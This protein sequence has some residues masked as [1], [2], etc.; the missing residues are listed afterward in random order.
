M[1][2]AS[3]YSSSVSRDYALL[4][5]HPASYQ[6]FGA[7]QADAHAQDD[8][9]SQLQDDGEERDDIASVSQ[10]DF[11]SNGVADDGMSQISLPH[12]NHLSVP[13]SPTF[14]RTNL[15]G[16][17]AG[18]L[19]PG[20]GGGA[21]SGVRRPSVNAFPN[22]AGIPS[23][24]LLGG[25][26][27]PP[28]ASADTA[29]LSASYRDVPDHISDIPDESDVPTPMP[30]APTMRYAYTQPARDYLEYGTSARR[31]DGHETSSLLS[32]RNE[33]GFSNYGAAPH[34]AAPNQ[35]M[36]SLVSAAGGPRKRRPSAGAGS[37]TPGGGPGVSGWAASSMV[38]VPVPGAEQIDS[39][40]HE[41]HDHIAWREAKVVTQYTI[42]IW[43]TH[44]LE[45]S[46]SVASV[47][48]LGHLGTLELAAA[49]LSSMTANVSGYSVLS[50]FISALD[51][52]LPSAYTQQPKSV[53]LWT[54]RMLV[55]IAGLLP[56]IWLIWFNAERILVATGQDPAVAKL[57]GQ[58]LSILA[59]GLPGYASFEVCRRYLQAQGLMH[60][61]TL[62]LLVVSPLN[63]IANYALVWGPESIR[64]GFVG[65][66]M[67][68]AISMWVMAL[69]C[70][71]QCVLGPRTAWDGWS[72]A[73]FKW[74]GIRPVLSLGF[75]GM[76]SLATEWWAWEIVGLVTAALGTTALAAQSVL[77][78]SSS[79]TYQL[80]FG[81][82]VATAVRIGNLLGANRPR[83]ARISSNVSLIISLA[84]GGF[85]SA[86]FLIF[87]RQWGYLFSSDAEVIKL[88]EHILPI[89][90]I[91]QVADG[92]CGIAGGVLRGTGRQAQGAII[93]LT[94]YYFVGIPI[95]L[96]LTF[97]KLQM[98]LEGLWWGLTIA[99]LYGSVGIFWLICRTDWEHEVRK[100]QLRM[101]LDD[102]SAVAEAAQHKDDVEAHPNGNALFNTTSL[103][104]ATIEEGEEDERSE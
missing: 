103:A 17:A 12:Q 93:N 77:L 95:G 83:E 44:L 52:I 21:A 47:F 36:L 66:P 99:L 65:A 78:V 104:S 28:P 25:S 30:L 73:A 76:C 48:S 50:G 84:M 56:L 69:L 71:L 88:V 62:V 75:A 20:V 9:S 19:V 8:A 98:G 102:P 39:I 10:D 22:V 91:F 74:A 86:L 15:G 92:V 59:F 18:H 58:Y 6:H 89:L 64:L 57:A 14:H 41:S 61:P 100:V 13:D 79:V 32:R 35:S 67:A 51:T 16:A 38:P 97:S 96:I 33:S 68:S 31:H 70:F 26:A 40:E 27:I 81:A 43:A 82:S 46:L 45:L 5:G 80:P 54:Q 63:A 90:A 87:R 2:F 94:A 85:N 55:I 42:P 53:G 101:T 60:A 1:S 3:R 7:L 11:V 4:Q 23:E 72:M 37:I 24:Y 49:S 29:P 34:D